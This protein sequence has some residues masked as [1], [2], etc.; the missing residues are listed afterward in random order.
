[1]KSGKLALVLAIALA[2][3]SSAAYRDKNGAPIPG[4]PVNSFED[5]SYGILSDAQAGL[6][7]TAANIKSGA[8]PQSIIPDYDRA[9]VLYNQAIKGL[10]KYDA[11]V[12]AGADASQIQ[13]EITQQISELVSLGLKLWPKTPA[14]P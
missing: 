4:R 14:K 7:A 2:G 6:K 13:T 12:R 1:M 8:L 3:C 9:A 11:D 10:K 5:Y